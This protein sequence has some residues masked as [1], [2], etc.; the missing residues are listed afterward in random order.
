MEYSNQLNG[1]YR[2]TNHTY[3]YTVIFSNGISRQGV[4]YKSL[5]RRVPEK[6][7]GSSS[8]TAYSDKYDYEPAS[9]EEIHHLNECIE[10]GKPLSIEETMKTYISPILQYQI[11]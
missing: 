4:K 5:D 3:A 10:T 7:F 2:A 9:P 6:F 1:V 11:Y 8:F